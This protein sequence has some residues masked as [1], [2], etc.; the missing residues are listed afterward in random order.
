MSFP[1]CNV[2]H[3]SRVNVYGVRIPIDFFC[4]SRDLSGRPW[5]GP[6]RATEGVFEVRESA[7]VAEHSAGQDATDGGVGDAAGQ[8][9]CSLT[10][11]GLGHR[12][13]QRPRHVLRDGSS[14]GSVRGQLPVWPGTSGHIFGGWPNAVTA[15]HHPTITPNATLDSPS[16]AHPYHAGAFTHQHGGR[17]T[18]GPA[19]HRGCVR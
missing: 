14:R 7:D 19:P 5:P 8:G 6:E 18:D 11:S 10:G 1:V 3:V 16:E 13:A 4:G 12:C 9:E 15:R 2:P 17:I